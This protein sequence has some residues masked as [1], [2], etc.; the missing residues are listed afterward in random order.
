MRTISE[1]TI[2][3]Y[4]NADMGKELSVYSVIDS[5]NNAAKLL[6]KNGAPHGAVVVAGRQTAGKGRLGRSFYSP[7]AEGIYMSVI[8]R[9]QLRAEYSILM[10]SA[11]S[12][13]AARAIELVSG[14]SVKIKWVNDLYWNGKKLCGILTESSLAPGGT[15]DYAVIGIGINVSTNSFPPEL[16]DKATSLA[17]A[18]CGEL[19]A[20]RLIAEIL[21][22]FAVVYRQLETR[23]FLEEYKA[24][25][26]VLGKTVQ[27]LRGEDVYEATAIDIDRDA[28]LLVATKSGEQRVLSS[29]EVSLK[30][31]WM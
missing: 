24:R 23:E 15:L 26:C 10:T 18:G 12:V 16:S 5:T 19:D 9:P 7:D 1:E 30:G 27:V 4:L 3:A 8:L 14:V 6:A 29:G 11:V 20:N 21:N 28:H 25:S 31:N 22:Q 13:A 2:K 17:A